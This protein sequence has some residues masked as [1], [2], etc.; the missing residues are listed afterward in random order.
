METRMREWSDVFVA[1]LAMSLASCAAQRAARQIDHPTTAD[2]AVDSAFPPTMGELSFESGGSKLNGL[3]YVANG[4]GPHPTVI[5]LHGYP[6]N[7]RNLDL[8]QAVRR[9]GMNVLYFNYRGTWGSG[10]EFSIAHALEDVAKAVERTRSEE[11]ASAYRADP[12]RVALVGHSLGGFLGAITTAEDERIA[13]FAFLAGADLGWMGLQAREDASTL[14]GLE[15]TFRQGMDARGGPVH[16]DARRVASEI[17]SRAE[18]WSV[19]SR[20]ADV[21]TRP[22]LL[23]AA[24][25]DG[26]T[27]QTDHHDRVIAALR[28]AGAERLTEV[29]LD[30]DHVF[31]AH[32]IELARRLVDW[33]R[34]ECWPG[35]PGVT[36]P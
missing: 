29:V 5:I 8:A 19:P 7:E 35:V 26:V 15:S 13:C 31:S 11:W 32:R 22:L 28:E 16:G 27:P 17:V 9:A 25:R 18:A 4:P 33:L 10:G 30:D 20:A 12:D 23:V 24:A 1:V 3:M 14:A 2:A 36:G 34:A 6:G 21:A